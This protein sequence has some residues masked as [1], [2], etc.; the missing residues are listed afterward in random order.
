MPFSI[1]PNPQ[2][3]AS[4][5]ANGLDFSGLCTTCRPPRL[6]VVNMSE[7][8][9]RRGPDALVRN[10]MKRIIC[11]DCGQPVSVQVDSD[12]ARSAG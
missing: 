9:R 4:L 7:L 12:S 1:P 3:I 8:I 2:T 6:L 5:A 10:V 11:R